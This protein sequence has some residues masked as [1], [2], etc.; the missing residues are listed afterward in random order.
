VTFPPQADYKSVSAFKANRRRFAFF[1]ERIK[2]VL[3]VEIQFSADGRKADGL[4]V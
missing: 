3:A 4:R 1:L 2:T